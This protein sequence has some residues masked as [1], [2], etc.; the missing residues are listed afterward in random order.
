[1]RL[2]VI[3]RAS[4]TSAKLKK[5]DKFNTCPDCGRLNLGLWRCNC[6]QNGSIPPAPPSSSQVP[7]S[8]TSDDP[9]RGSSRS[10]RSSLRGG[11]EREEALG[12]DNTINTK[13]SSQDLK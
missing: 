4:S 5:M 11:T 1:V 9:K 3:E 7:P 10:S 12:S 13:S 6:T 2:L 8:L